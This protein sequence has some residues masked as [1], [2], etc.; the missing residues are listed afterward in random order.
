MA[1]PPA[2]AAQRGIEIPGNR[3]LGLFNNDLAVRVLRL[4]TAAMIEAPI[5][6]YVTENADG[7]ATLSYI[8]P[9]I[10]LAPYAEGALGLD[11][12][13]AE[14]DAASAADDAATR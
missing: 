2:T 5:R 14:L 11:G 8:R 3:V 6:V 10:R 12:I 9:S 4:S 1:G 13:A 7:T